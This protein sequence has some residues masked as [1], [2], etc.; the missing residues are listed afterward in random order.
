[1]SYIMDV[2]A[3]GL[4]AVTNLFS[5]EPNNALIG[6]AVDGNANV[7]NNANVA[8]NAN[9]AN[10][11]NHAN[12]A[13]NAN[14]ADN[15]D[16]VDELVNEQGEV[17]E[18][19]ASVAP[20]VNPAVH[21]P[22]QAQAV[23]DN[24]LIDDHEINQHDEAMVPIGD[25]ANIFTNVNPVDVHRLQNRIG[26]TGTVLCMVCTVDSNSAVATDVAAVVYANG[27][28][29]YLLHYLRVP[30]VS[31]HG[32]TDELIPLQVAF[33]TSHNMSEKSMV[34]PLSRAYELNAQ[35]YL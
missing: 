1:M 22:P 6:D 33:T 32:F 14:N 8:H 15:A 5:M 12:N 7:A 4:G 25:W 13:N 29:F 10:N 20:I 11:A 34:L 19:D 35:R 9:V 31:I 23:Q 18:D 16:L 2:F 30:S 28:C 27:E 24:D 26:G 21:H 17:V 3:A